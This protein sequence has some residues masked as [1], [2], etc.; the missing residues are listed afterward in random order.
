MTEQEQKD[1]RK[2]SAAKQKAERQAEYDERQANFDWYI[3]SFWSA[4]EDY[5]RP[6]KHLV[7]DGKEVKSDV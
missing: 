3:R 5:P 7:K 1:K 6:V 4:E 2:A